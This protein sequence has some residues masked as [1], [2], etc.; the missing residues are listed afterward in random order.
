MLF[1]VAETLF[2]KAPAE[3]P[4]VAAG[5][6]YGV[7]DAR[8]LWVDVNDETGAREKSFAR[9]V[10]ENKL[11]PLSEIELAG[12]RDA[13]RVC[14]MVPK[15]GGWPMQFPQNFAVRKR[16]PENDR[17]YHELESLLQILEDVASYDQ[18]SLG[19]NFLARRVSTI[20]EALNEGPSA[21]NWSQSK[22]IMAR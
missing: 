16:L 3:Q 4:D 17:N 19:G 12:R 14:R 21:A 7:E 22:E 20:T 5:V 18:L 8:T 9:A 1:A 13:L 2:E 15:G 11:E 10:A 6:E